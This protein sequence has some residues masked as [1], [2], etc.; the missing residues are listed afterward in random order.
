MI[1]HPCKVCGKELSLEADDQCEPHWLKVFLSMLSCNRCFDLRAERLEVTYRI[2]AICQYLRAIDGFKIKPEDRKRK[3]AQV[4]ERLSIRTKEY[5]R[6]FR[7]ALNGRVEVWSEEFVDLLLDA[8][9]KCDEILKQYRNGARAEV[10]GKQLEETI[11]AG[12][13]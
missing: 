8:P 13:L 11:A 9:D 10:M 5:A 3:R 12:T 4:R 1:T 7:K 6:W 2:V